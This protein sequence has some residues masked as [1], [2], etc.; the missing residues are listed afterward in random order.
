MAE[1]A[2]PILG[3]VMEKVE[4]LPELSSVF[5]KRAQPDRKQPGKNPANRTHK[6][7]RKAGRK[8]IFLR[9]KW[10]IFCPS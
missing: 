1:S 2:L 4:R 7:K 8:G 9:N 6:A 3:M 10:F 5:P